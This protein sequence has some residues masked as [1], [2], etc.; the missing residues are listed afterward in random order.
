MSENHYTQKRPAMNL[1][2]GH[3][4]E[5]KKKEVKFFLLMHSNRWKLAI[6]YFEW[7]HLIPFATHHVFVLFSELR[8]T[9]LHSVIINYN[10]V[11]IHILV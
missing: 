11:T 3:N 9:L 6:L 5:T 4:P 10:I 8:P 7:K 1:D 2:L